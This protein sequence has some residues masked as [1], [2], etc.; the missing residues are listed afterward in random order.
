MNKGTT[1]LQNIQLLKWC[2]EYDVKPRVEP[3][4]RVSRGAPIGLRRDAPAGG[5][6][7]P[8]STRPPPTGLCGSIGSVPTTTTQSGTGSWVY[9]PQA[10]YRFLYPDN[11]RLS[12]IAY[13]FDFDYADGRDPLTYAQPLLARVQYWMDNGPS[14]G[15]W[16]VN[17]DDDEVT[18]VRDDGAGGRSVVRL[19]GWQARVYARSRS[20]AGTCQA[21]RDR[22]RGRRHGRARRLPGC[23]RPTAAHG[24]RRRSVPQPR[25]EPAGVAGRPVR[26]DSRATGSARERS[27]LPMVGA[28]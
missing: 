2:R 12:R 8:S 17:R 5:G 9:A 26:P 24:P 3:P 25:R 22:G 16:I 13:Y 1:A 23:L 7:R 20:C 10:P 19:N 15:V 27:E 14:G 4:V 18:I 21:R 28:R 6:H 11:E